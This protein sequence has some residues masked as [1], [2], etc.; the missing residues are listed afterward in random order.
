MKILIIGNG[1]L[2]NRCKDVWGEHAVIAGARDLQTKTDVISL[3]ENHKP[4]AILNAAGRKGK[5]NVDWCETNQLETIVG[6]TL[7]PILVAQ[8][9]QD[10]GVYLLHI[11]SGCIFYS[12]SDHVDG[13]WREA[14]FG[15]PIP[16][17]SRTKWAADLVLSTLPNV[18]IA[19]IRMPLD[20]MPHPGN[21]ITKLA[22][23]PKVIDVENS[24]TIIEDMIDVFYKLMQVQATGIFH[25]TN[26]GKLKH[27]QIISLYEKYVDPEHKNEWITNVDLVEK[28]LA[29]KG[30]SNNFLYSE[31]LEKYGIRMRDVDEAI[32]DAIKKYAKQVKKS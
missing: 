24:V 27:R 3:I 7:Q 15:N 8:A 5:P 22:S 31:N 25:V 6:N 26:P 4:D 12:D 20:C 30:R 10:K 9:A 16:V 1:Y 18:G 32:T 17:Y 14:D 11:G 28:G 29:E 2:G 21:L 19:R 13:Q 23:Y